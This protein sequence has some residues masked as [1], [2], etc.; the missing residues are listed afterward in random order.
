MCVQQERPNTK[1]QPPTGR[2]DGGRD[3]SGE[4]ESQRARSSAEAADEEVCVRR[5]EGDGKRTQN[6]TR[7]QPRAKSWHVRGEVAVIRCLILAPSRCQ[8]NGGGERER[9]EEG[10]GEEGGE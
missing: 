5:R 6:T 2:R 10:E 4:R 7:A 9:E 8:L 3:R 1:L